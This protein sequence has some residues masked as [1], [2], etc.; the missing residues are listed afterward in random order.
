MH[1]KRFALFAGA[2]MPLLTIGEDDDEPAVG[3]G[4]AP[5]PAAG[6][7]PPAPGGAGE[8][9]EGGDGGAAPPPAA[10]AEG[11]AGDPPPAPEPKPARIPW[12][13][14]RIDQLTARATAAEER[15]AQLERDAAAARER[16]AAYEALYGRSD[17]PP[18]GG[19]PPPPPPPPGAGAAPRTDGARVYTQAELDAEVARAANLRVLNDRCETMFQSGGTKHGKDWSNR[20]Q[21]AGQAFGPELAKRADF[22]DALTGLPNPEDVYFAL[23]GDLDHLADVLTMPPVKMGMELAR[24]SVENGAAPVRQPRLSNAPPPIVPVENGAGGGSGAQG[25]ET[26]EQ[27][28]ARRE[29]EREARFA[30]RR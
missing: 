22:F 28:A 18:A 1:V 21:A 9:G 17:D 10:G 14:R 5:T 13:N 7:P 23:V 15:A 20:I 3:A 11:G 2:R 8:G 26:T 19:A 27:Y 25:E 24:L 6:D 12:Q 16:A 29:R 30:A 4:A